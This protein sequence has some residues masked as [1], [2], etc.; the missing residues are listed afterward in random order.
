V[1]YTRLSEQEQYWTDTVQ[2][3]L[4]E[5]EQADREDD[6]RFGKGRT[7][8]ELPAELAN[9]QSRLKR[10]REAK[11]QLEEEAARELAEA[12]S[13]RQPRRCGRPRKDEQNADPR[14]QAELAKAKKRLQRAKRNAAQPARS[15]NLT[16]GDSRIMRDNARKCMVQ[17]YNAQIAVDAKAQVIVAADVTQQV[18]DRAQLVPMCERIRESLGAMPGAITADAG[19]WDTLSIE[20]A[21]ASGAQILVAPD[22]T[23]RHAKPRVCQSGESVQRMRK[24]LSEG[25]AR[26][27]YKLRKAIVEPVF[28][29][30]K[31][32]RGMRGFCVRGMHKVKAEWQV[33]CLTHNLLKLFRHSWLPQ[34]A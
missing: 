7:G 15:L 23:H 34:P 12:S 14:S 28:G 25:P 29:Q 27:L 8:E 3:L 31:Q 24:L 16:D 13:Q 18:V 17:A 2:R 4:R 22:A 10:I 5:A 32:A 11:K 30:I 9:V 1:S 21:S 20:R 19:Y 6:N 26:A 33:I